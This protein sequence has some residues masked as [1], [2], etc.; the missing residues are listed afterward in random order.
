M[1]R[2]D[3]DHR[4]SNWTATPAMTIWTENRTASGKPGKVKGGR[5]EFL[6]PH[7]LRGQLLRPGFVRM[8]LRLGVAQ[9]M[10]QW[11]KLQFINGGVDPRD[12]D[13]VLGRIT[14]LNSWVD[15]WE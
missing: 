3:V 12:L 8:S 2:S 1:K 14:S 9:Q 7:L 6:V 13:D 5:L 4:N 10:P 15:E 11:A